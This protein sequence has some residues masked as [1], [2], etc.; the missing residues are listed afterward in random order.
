MGLGNV[1]PKYEEWNNVVSEFNQ[2]LWHQHSEAAYQIE[3]DP[4]DEDEQQQ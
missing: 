2:L 1:D 4:E 3:H